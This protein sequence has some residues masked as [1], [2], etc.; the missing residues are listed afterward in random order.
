[1][2]IPG[3]TVHRKI[4]VGGMASVFLATQESFDR[5]VALKII[6]NKSFGGD[7]QA[8]RFNREAKII[9]GL[10]HPHI[11]P[12]YD[13]GSIGQYQY[14]AMDYLP[15]GELGQL[16]KAGLEPEECVQIISQIAQALDFAHRK[17]Y[18]HRDVKPDNIMFREDL[19][20]V[21]TDFGIARPKETDN[22]M[23]Q[24]GMTFGTPSYMS[25]EQSQNKNVDGRTDLYALGVI[26]F[27]ML[28]KKLPYQDDDPLALAIKH[29]KEPVPRLP[30]QSSHYQIIIDKLMAK[31][32]D[33][34]YQTGLELVKALKNLDPKTQSKQQETNTKMELT[35]SEQ[36][37]GSDKKPE[38]SLDI[39]ENSY[40]KLGLFKQQR[41]H[42]TIASNEHQHFSIL[43]SQLT[44]R[45]M[46]WHVAH[47]K[48]CGHV[49]FD[50]Y[51][52]ELIKKQ[53]QKLVEKLFE[54]DSPYAFLKKI[55][56]VVNYK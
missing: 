56:F 22:N 18:I 13:V 3:Y 42:G 45:L 31:N 4:G 2:K 46:E 24:Q 14:L 28:T 38:Q 50:F 47:E 15:N 11:V 39:I 54:G 51:V 9:A 21:L 10:S 49:I 1:M 48:N 55:K 41:F 12:V 44:T 17:G 40:R 19:S 27:L 16:I 20:A 6:A 52:N 26:F 36:E 32:P 53:A 8:L 33:D 43:F 34:R 23:T 29:I 5:K 25:P 35:L 37:Q 30:A 7:E